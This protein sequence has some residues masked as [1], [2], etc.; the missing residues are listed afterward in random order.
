MVE[1]LGIPDVLGKF[2]LAIQC[3]GCRKEGKRRKAKAR[4]KARLNKVQHLKNDPSSH[5]KI[6][7]Q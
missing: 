1:R 2:E 3:A 5:I 7:L 6:M 4:R